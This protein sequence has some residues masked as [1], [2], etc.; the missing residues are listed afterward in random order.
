MVDA[1]D[2]A[3]G[4][5]LFAAQRD[6][7]RLVVPRL[8]RLHSAGRVPELTVGARDQHGAHTLGAVA[9]EDPARPDRFVVGMGVH[10]HEGEGTLWHGGSVGVR[11]APRSRLQVAHRVSQVLELG[12][13]L[14]RRC[15]RAHDE[16]GEP[17]LQ[18]LLQHRPQALA[19]H[20]DDLFERSAAGPAGER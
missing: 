1:Q 2:L 8:T 12:S 4:F 6:D 15:H 11:A 13:P 16:L 7:D 19:S 18:E 20:G 17:H 3:T 5:E 9:G 10:R 14:P